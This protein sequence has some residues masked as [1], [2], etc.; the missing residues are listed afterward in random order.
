MAENSQQITV[1][2]KKNSVGRN[3]AV[4][5]ILF[6][7]VALP[8][9]LVYFQV[10][11][12]TMWDSYTA[13]NKNNEATVYFHDA[14]LS[15]K[16]DISIESYKKDQKKDSLIKLKTQLDPGKKSPNDE[17]I[18]AVWQTENILVITFRGDG[19]QPEVIQIDFSGSQISY[20][21]LS[22]KTTRNTVI[23]KKSK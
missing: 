4:G 11:G 18:T 10:V 1:E 12:Y 21:T 14:W 17:S 19:Q 8:I 13:L 6:L 3:V 5:I 22:G 9:T 16:M 20:E 2:K 7:L 23:T 15:G